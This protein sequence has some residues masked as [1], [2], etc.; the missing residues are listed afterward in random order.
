MRPTRISYGVELNMSPTTISYG[1]EGKYEAYQN[2]L[3]C[4]G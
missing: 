4:G 2:K 1:V 3:W